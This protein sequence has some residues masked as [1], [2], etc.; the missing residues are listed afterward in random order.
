[1]ERYIYDIKLNV[2]IELSEMHRSDNRESSY[3]N[4]YLARIIALQYLHLNNRCIDQTDLLVRV[5]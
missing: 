5:K 1:M 3:L 4:W 2:Y